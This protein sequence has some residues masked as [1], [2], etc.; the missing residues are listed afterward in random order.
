MF[1]GIIEEVGFVKS[2]KKSKDGM[3]LEISCSKVIANAKI[4]DSIAVNGVCI[5]AKAVADSSFIGDL[6]N[7]TLNTTCL[8]EIKVMESVNL[9]SALTLSKPMGGHFVTGHVDTK[10][11]VSSVQK[12][13]F[14]KVVEIAYPKEFRANLIDKGSIAV[15]GVSLTIHKLTDSYLQIKLIPHSMSET[16]LLNIGKADLVNLEFDFLGKYALNMLRNIKDE[17]ENNISES[18]LMENGFL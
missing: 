1:T 13:G 4:G 5:T 18:F 11:I 14:S 16:N 17:K 9:E 2:I 10:A 12:E 8:K 3:E 7:E 6:M 15:D